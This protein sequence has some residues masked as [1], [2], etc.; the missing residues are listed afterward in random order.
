MREHE[1]PSEPLLEPPPGFADRV[2]GAWSTERRRTRR[3]RIAAGAA[4]LAL[5][6]GAALLRAPP[7]DVT[8][9]VR[10]DR[11]ALPPTGGEATVMVTVSA[12]SDDDAPVALAIVIDNGASLS[13]PRLEN[14]RRALAAVSAE[15][16]PVDR[17]VLVADRHRLPDADALRPVPAPCVPCA[18]DLAVTALAEAPAPVQRTLVVITDGGLQRVVRDKA[19]A[20]WQTHGVRTATVGIGGRFPPDAIEAVATSGRGHFY[21][22]HNSALVGELL[23]AELHAAR[24]VALTRARISVAGTTLDLGPVGG[25]RMALLPLDVSPDDLADGLN[26]NLEA[27]THAGGRVTLSRP[28]PLQIAT[29]ADDSGERDPVVL[30]EITRLAAARALVDALAAGE[31]GDAAAARAALSRGRAALERLPPAQRGGFE[32]LARALQSMPRAP[33]EVAT[34]HRVEAGRLFEMQRGFDGENN[35][36]DADGVFSAMELE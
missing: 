26:V 1:T 28:A 36:N 23:T 12:T 6:V 13:G 21:F 20:A 31:D 29:S 25:E 15:M 2:V 9:A 7:V 22:A 4:V 11:S 18:F 10:V 5:V 24:S 33:V 32:D 16:S 8:L 35:V 17:L 19:A 34:R 14:M 27:R 3:R 30:A